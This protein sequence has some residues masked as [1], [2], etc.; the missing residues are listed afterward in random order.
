METAARRRSERRNSATLAW[1]S[2]AA[3]PVSREQPPAGVTP[4]RW[5]ET[6][7]PLTTRRVGRPLLHYDRVASTMPLAHELAV[8]GAGD[9]TTLIAEEQTAGRGRRGRGWTAP[10]GTAILCSIIFRPP[11]RPDDLFALT[12]A[13]GLGICRGVERATGLPLSVKWP[14]DLLLAGRKVAGLLCVTRLAGSTLD[15][16]VVGFGLN[17]NLRADQLPPATAGALGATSL[18]L[19][20]GQPVDR[21]RL[22]ATVLEGIDQAYDL[23]LSGGNEALHAAWRDRL[24]GLGDTIRIE[25]ESGAVEGRFSDVTPDGALLLLTPVGLER[26]LVGD[27][28]LGPRPSGSGASG[29]GDDTSWSREN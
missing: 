9:G 5:D 29:D 3:L 24:A 20:L 13:V 10:H 2:I 1:F 17:V 23:L 25:T 21:L 7:L 18:T 19:A 26:V 12:A 16:A 15:H 22:L 11:L 6:V 4:E 8:A 28:I 27:V 14:N